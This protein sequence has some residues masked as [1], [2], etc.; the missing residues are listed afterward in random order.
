M[1]KVLQALLIGTIGAAAGGIGVGILKKKDILVQGKIIERYKEYYKLLNEWVLLKNE[2]KSLEQYL[3]ENKYKSIAIYGMGEL[4]CR[5]YEELKNSNI[6]IKYA[7]DQSAN[8]IDEELDVLSMEDDLDDVDAIIVTVTYAF[9][10][11]A[12]KLEDK[13]DCEI[14]SLEDLIFNL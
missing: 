1:K 5:L 7:I 10:E 4:G 2:G 6:E 8:D 3:V 13:I 14:I 11:I 12:E 9:D